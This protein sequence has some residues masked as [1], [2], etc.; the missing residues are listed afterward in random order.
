MPSRAY[1]RPT[2]VMMN[3]RRTGQGCITIDMGAYIVTVAWESFGPLRG[4]DLRDRYA[5]P[6]LVPPRL[7]RGSWCPYK[8]R[9]SSSLDLGL[10]SEVP[11]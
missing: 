7:A 11:V 5:H 10:E 9:F 2:L 6:R 4:W 3:F 1:E 8:D